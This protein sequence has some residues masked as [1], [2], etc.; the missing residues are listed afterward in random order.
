MIKPA[1]PT[2]PPTR[3]RVDA[4][5]GVAVDRFFNLDFRRLDFAFSVGVPYRGAVF[6]P[7]LHV[8]PGE[9]P[10]GLQSNRTELG[11]AIRNDARVRVAAGLHLTHTMVLRKSVDKPLFEAIFGGD[12]AGLGIGPH[13]V[14]SGDLIRFTSSAALTV[15]V[16]GMVEVFD[17]GVAY[18]A[19]ANLGFGFGAL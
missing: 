3:L 5:A 8:Q 16:R 12:I 11:L 13:V 18:G 19:G 7:S 14:F 10:N 6:E 15:S 17:D 9:T 2:A 4:R 1:R